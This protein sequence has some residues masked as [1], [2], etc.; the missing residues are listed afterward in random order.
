M[1]FAHFLVLKEG[2]RRVCKEGDVMDKAS[3]EDKLNE[4][5]KELK[6]GAGPQYMKLAMLAHQAGESH[7]QLQKSFDNLQ[8]AL[9]YLRICIK[10]Q[11]FDL[12]A[13]RRENDYLRK[14][15]REN[16]S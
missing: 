16:D 12:E 15:L 7:K 11:L 8:D 5:I 14:L 2:L 4:L 6:G 13:T 9:D 3:L 1:R 10:Y